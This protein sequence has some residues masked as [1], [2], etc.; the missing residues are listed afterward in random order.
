MT[1]ILLT[2]VRRNSYLYIER[3]LLIAKSKSRRRFR[4]KFKSHDLSVSRDLS[5]ASASRERKP[6]VRLFNMPMLFE[7]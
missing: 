6:K 3:K 7:F 4:N 1:S 5:N 2:E